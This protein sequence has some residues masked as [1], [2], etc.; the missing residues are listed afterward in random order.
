LAEQAWRRAGAHGVRTIAPGPGR[1]FNDEL[2]ALLA[3]GEVCQ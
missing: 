1:D 2:R 3:S